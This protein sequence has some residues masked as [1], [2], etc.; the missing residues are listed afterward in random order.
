MGALEAAR[1]RGG[2]D[3]GV[4]ALTVN[5]PAEAVD[6]LSATDLSPHYFQWLALLEALHLLGNYERE[7][8]EARRGRKAYPGRLQMLDAEIR[9]LAALGRFAEAERILDESL[10]LPGEDEITPATLMANAAAELRAHGHGYASSELRDR[11]I[12][13][14]MLHSAQEQESRAQRYSL[15]VAYYEGKRWEEARTLFRQLSA[16]TPQDVHVLGYLGTLAARLGER[17]EAL[18]ISESLS[19]TAAPPEF[20]EDTYKQARIASLLGDLERAVAL[21]RDAFAHGMAFSI[22]VH[23]D[24]DLDPLYDNP[25]FQEFIRPKG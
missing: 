5:R 2:I 13:W 18:G 11:A 25:A 6:V 9:A 8:G 20:G 21:L 24:I 19:G 3:V 15:A 1:A 4:Q 14:L 17:A 12:A 23:R 10:L 7:L 22:A 16:E